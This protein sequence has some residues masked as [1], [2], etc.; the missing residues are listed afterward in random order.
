MLFTGKEFKSIIQ[1]LEQEWE[2]GDAE[3]KGWVVV[4]LRKAFPE[5]VERIQKE[6]DK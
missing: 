6:K 5:I 3:T 4:Q 1:E 2:Q